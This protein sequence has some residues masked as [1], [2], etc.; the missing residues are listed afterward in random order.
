R[1]GWC[2]GDRSGTEPT[3]PPRRARRRPKPV[4]RP[5]RSRTRPEEGP[6]RGGGCRDGASRARVSGDE[7]VGGVALPGDVAGLPDQAL[8]LRARGAA[9]GPGGA[10]HV[11]FDHDA[12][13]VVRTELQGDLADLLPLGDPGRLEVRD[14]IE[15]EPRDGLRPEVVGARDLAAA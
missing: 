8:D 10:Y 14:V 5:R 2:W 4:H 12:A 6:R 11:L 13:H 15:V 3:R 9:M 1:R 7:S